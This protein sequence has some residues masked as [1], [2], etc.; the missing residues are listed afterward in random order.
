MVCRLFQTPSA[1]EII[2]QA[3]ENNTIKCR[4]VKELFS[5]RIISAWT[6]DDSKEFW[7]ITTKFSNSDLLLNSVA[8]RIS[9]EVNPVP[10]IANFTDLSQEVFLLAAYGNLNG[11]FYGSCCCN[12]VLFFVCLPFVYVLTIMTYGM[13]WRIMQIEERA[14]NRGRRRAEVNDNSL[15][16]RD[17]HNSFY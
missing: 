5:E 8:F 4:H 16:V 15:R 14:I 1:V 6:E 11:L 2:E 12:L 3:D 9:R 10:A 17:L 13:V 7:F